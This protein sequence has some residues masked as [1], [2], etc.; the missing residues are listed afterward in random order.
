MIE[1]VEQKTMAINQDT[2]DFMARQSNTILIQSDE[3]FIIQNISNN[4]SDFGIEFGSLD[5]LPLSNILNHHFSKYKNTHTAYSAEDGADLIHI[6]AKDLLLHEIQCKRHIEGLLNY[7]EEGNLI[8]CLLTIHPKKSTQKKS[9]REDVKADYKQ[10]LF[11]NLFETAGDAIFV[12]NG[13]NFI[14]CNQKALEMFA[15]TREQI[16][17]HSP[18]EYSPKLQPDGRSSKESAIEK[19]RASISGKEMKFEW[20]HCKKDGTPFHAQVSLNTLK[21]NDEVLIQ[22]IVRDIDEAK[23]ASQKLAYSEEFNRKLMDASPMGIVHL[24]KKGNI[25][26]E[27]LRLSEIMSGIKQKRP[28]LIG[29][30]IFELPGII[31]GK[32]G[33]Y[34]TY[35]IEGNSI[36]SEEIKYTSIH[37]KEVDIEINGAPIFSKEGDVEGA[38]LII[39]DISRRLK[40]ESEK[41]QVDKMYRLIFENSPLGIGLSTY[42]GKLLAFNQKLADYFGYSEKEF[43]SMHTANLYACENERQKVLNILR[44]KENLKDYEVKL[45]RRDGSEFYAEL[46][47]HSY[48]FENEKAMM[49]IVNDISERIKSAEHIHKLTASVEQSPS[50][51]VIT[52]KEGRIEYINSMFSK[53]IGKTLKQV[54]GKYA[55]EMIDQVFDSDKLTKLRTELHENGKIITEVHHKTEEGKEI[56]GR[57]KVSA[58]VDSNQEV[59]NYLGIHEDITIQKNHEIEMKRARE[60]AEHSDKIKTIFLATMSHELRTPLNAIIG[61]SSI[62][63]SDAENPETRSFGNIINKS[64]EHLLSIIND[65]FDISIIE[66]GN[67]KLHKEQF[68]LKKFFDEIHQILHADQERTGKF[69]VELKAYLPQNMENQLILTDKS[70]LSQIFVNLLKNAFKF[71][72]SGSV[73]FGLQQIEGNSI[74]F[75]VKDTGIGIPKEKQDLIFNL[76][77]QVDDTYTRKT[78]GAGIGLSL[79]KKLV[80]C[81]GGSIELESKENE[82]ST[83][84]VTLNDVIPK[85]QIKQNSMTLKKTAP[86]LKGKNI[87]VA[88]DEE[89][90]FKLLNAWIK[91]TGANTTWV[92][93]GQEAVDY[94]KDNQQIDLVL[95]DVKMPHMNG[96]T[97]TQLIKQIQSDLPIIVQTAYALSGDIEK[98]QLSGGDSYV[99]KPLSRLKLYRELSKFL[100]KE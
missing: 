30:N 73:E 89:S 55:M 48:D 81:M 68:K 60:M 59:T 12:M 95:M 8:S 92:K 90:N 44:E 45:R 67:I 24:D 6:P 87:L 91:K 1:I 47:I 93:N 77:E 35:L 46:N 97:A 28:I 3:N 99:S 63:G 80:E 100:V 78:N 43:K 27:N 23:K 62:I 34:F 17:G 72:E 25:T 7:T 10:D 11:E 56:W 5:G 32:L 57:L 38:I 75:Y 15:C 86:N 83:F 33:H 13:N 82:G 4:C 66:T 36:I 74:T 94:I 41:I 22:A 50:S 70:R 19:I 21:V 65:M 14:D 51:I 49:V 64:G 37:N 76:F 88:E 69:H 29:R 61:F 54:Q 85:P 96:Y 2:I 58:I 31:N 52:D 84:Y 9:K 53:F 79:C 98:A 40:A 26:Y 42:S 20:I 39:M 18:F 71:T 16:I